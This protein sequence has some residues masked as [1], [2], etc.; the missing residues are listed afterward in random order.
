LLVGRQDARLHVMDQT[1]NPLMKSST[2]VAL[3]VGLLLTAAQ[4]WAIYYDARYGVSHYQGEVA[5]ALPA[6]R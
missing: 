1:R 4:F 2:F 6:H 5:T 3:A